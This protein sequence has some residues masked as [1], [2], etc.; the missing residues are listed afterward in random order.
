[1][2]KQKAFEKYYKNCSYRQICLFLLQFCMIFSKLLLMMNTFLCMMMMIW[3]NDSLLFN[4]S[5]NE[6]LTLILLNMCKL[7]LWLVVVNIFVVIFIVIC[8]LLFN[9][10]LNFIF[11]LIARNLIPNQRSHAFQPIWLRFI[12]IL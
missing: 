7:L 9:L 5:W 3:T 1:V 10:P 4:V 11:F 12:F 8:F 6:D 2:P